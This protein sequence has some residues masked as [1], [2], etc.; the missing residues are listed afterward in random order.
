VG[1]CKNNEFPTILG[2]GQLLIF[3][4]KLKMTGC[5]LYLS[6]WLPLRHTFGKRSCDRNNFGT[7]VNLR[8]GG[9]RTN[10]TIMSPIPL[11]L[12]LGPDPTP[13]KQASRLDDWMIVSMEISTSSYEV[14]A[15][16]PLP[17]PIC[18]PIV[19]V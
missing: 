17:I 3:R 19:K 8:S 5:S 14:M 6:L 18:T 4:P 9:L 11:S 13:F 1:R 10:W 12:R 15:N 16:W 7:N 2:G